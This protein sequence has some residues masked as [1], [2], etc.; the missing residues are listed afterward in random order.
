MHY[1]MHSFSSRSKYDHITI[2]NLYITYTYTI[3]IHLNNG[4]V[5]STVKLNL[6][7]EWQISGSE[8]KPIVYKLAKEHHAVNEIVCTSEKNYLINAR[9][10]LLKG[11]VVC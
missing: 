10:S 8:T 11:C 3:F 9:R 5:Q 2:S 1:Y 7:Y 6:T 4:V